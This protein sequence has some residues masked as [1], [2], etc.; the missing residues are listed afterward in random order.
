MP[1]TQ[2]PNQDRFCPVAL[3]RFLG[4]FSNSARFVGLAMLVLTMLLARSA[5]ARPNIISL[6]LFAGVSCQLISGVSLIN[7]RFSY[8]ILERSCAL[9]RCS[10]IVT[11][12]CGV[13]LSWALPVQAAS[14]I[15]K[16]AVTGSWTDASKWTGGVPTAT[17]SA[18]FNNGGTYTVNFSNVFKILIT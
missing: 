10:V 17:D 12:V 14:K 11:I 3:S 8:R 15:W 9:S 18:T 4:A 5:M 16:N 7:R 2:Q 13:S 1:P 6:G